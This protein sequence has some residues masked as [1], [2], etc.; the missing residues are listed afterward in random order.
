M[1]IG[2]A[3]R[4]KIVSGRRRRCRAL[5]RLGP[6]G[7]RWG[8]LPF[9]RYL[10]RGDED[11]RLAL[12]DL[13]NR[14]RPEDVRP[15]LLQ[16]RGSQRTRV[17]S[18]AIQ[19]RFRRAPG[20]LGG[21]DGRDGRRS[22]AVAWGRCAPAARRGEAEARPMNPVLLLGDE[23][24]IVVAVA[25]SLHARGVPVDVAAMTAGAPRIVSRAVRRWSRVPDSPEGDEALLAGILDAIETYGYDYLIPASDT[26]LSVLARHH[27]DFPAGVRLGCPEPSAVLAVL[28]KSRTLEAAVACGV[29]VPEDYRLDS[30]D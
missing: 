20:G 24:R 3:W 21:G 15:T 12:A 6:L 10:A 5:L 17:W 25:R 18:G 13:R 19:E 2:P 23:P 11:R 22:A 16:P 8:V 27:G 29:P 30:E 28:D 7:R 4:G 9:R 1:G 14:R 26:A